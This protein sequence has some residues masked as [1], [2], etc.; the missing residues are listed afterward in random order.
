MKIIRIR[1]RSVLVKGSF[2]GMIIMITTGVFKIEVGSGQ[3]IGDGQS[4][5]ER[6]IQHRYMHTKLNGGS[7]SEIIKNSDMISRYV[8]KLILRK[9]E[10][11]ISNK[12]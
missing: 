7:D 2:T 11:C 1:V 3:S 9:M 6:Y 4:L 10:D 8:Y 5:R 12:L